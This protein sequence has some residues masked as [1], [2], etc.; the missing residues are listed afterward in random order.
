MTMTPTTKLI[1]FAL[2]LALFT[3][4]CGGSTPAA[5]TP[6]P[7]AN[8][9]GGWTGTFQATQGTSPVTVAFIMDLTQA[10]DSVNGTYS[11]SGG[12]TFNGTVSGATTSSSFSGTFT[13]N[14]RTVSGAACTGT[15]VA[16]GNAGSSTMTW[17]SPIVSATCTN[18]PT[19][20][21]IAVQRR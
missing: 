12:S 1:P 7:P 3:S 4:A 14:A 6:P 16:S 15:F 19:S 8:I 18:T 2:A 5:P 17:T 13:F 21:T 20:M 11:T 9:A 10:G